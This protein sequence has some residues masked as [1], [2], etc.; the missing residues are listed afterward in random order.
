MKALLLI[1]LQ[2][3]F[4]PGGNLPVPDGFASIHAA[5]KALPFFNHVIATQDWHPQEHLSF[6]KNHPG[7]YPGENINLYGISQVLWPVHCVQESF[8]A[9]LVGE[10]DKS[11]IHHVVRKGFDVTIDSYSAFFDNA[12]R[13]ETGLFSYLQQKSIQEIYLLGVALEYCVKYSALDAISLGIKTN[14]IVDGCRGIGQ[15]PQ[16]IP[17]ALLEMHKNGVRLLKLE[18]LSREALDFNA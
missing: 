11:K 1:D 10:L 18:D 14:V 15:T 4:M 3:D 8:G 2:N 17:E 12:R 13:H 5:N 9:S 16:D 7:K 6:A